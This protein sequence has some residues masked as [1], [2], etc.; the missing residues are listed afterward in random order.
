MSLELHATVSGDE[1]CRRLAA[2]MVGRFVELAGGSRDASAKAEAEVQ[3]ALDAV[4]S[5][6]A[7]IAIAI[8]RAGA[9]VV[10]NVSCGTR[11]AECTIGIG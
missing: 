11:D 3:A 6:A 4:A 1:L 10:V 2:E 8:R 9:A 7:E 5:G